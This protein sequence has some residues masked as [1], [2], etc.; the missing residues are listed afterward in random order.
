VTDNSGGTATKTLVVT[1]QNRAPTASFTATP[2]PSVTNATVTFNASAAV[3][4]DGTISKYEW[5]LDSN[6]SFETNGGTNK[7]TTRS[8]TT[9]GARTIGLRITDN[10]GATATTT[11][12]VTIQ[13]APPTPS[14]T[15]SP[16][17]ATANTT[18]TFNASASTDSNGTITKYE[19]DLDGNG[20]YETNGGTNKTTTRVYATASQV[21]VGLR[22]TDNEGATATTTQT[23][24]VRGPYNA[25]ISGTSDL[26]DYW[27]L[28]EA[29]GSTF[30]DPIGGRDATALNG[31]TL[32]SAGA[33]TL[34]TNTAA[35]FDGTNDAATASLNLS[36]TR[37]LT[38][39]FWLNWSTYAND[40]KLAFEFTPNFNNTNGGFLI[41]PNSSTSSGRF[42]VA[43]G[44]NG[45]RNNA[46]FTRPSAGAWHHYAIVL[47][48]SAL[49]SSQYI[50]VYVDG[51]AV[52]IT[53]GS[54]GNGAGSFANSTLYFMSRN[55]N[56]LFGKGA[57]D[58]VAIYDNT[59]S[60]TQIAQHY[61]AR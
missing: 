5:D 53:K 34:D 13:N 45:T 46:Y 60:A 8:Y 61:A 38:V 54:S 7:T 52:S 22:I 39:E 6:G 57:L 25:A 48:T 49:L 11:Q 27:R 41:N 9:V 59:L 42:E 20:S 33:L 28:G 15:V 43:I 14:F 35:S 16:S 2:N 55:G 30:D 58:E 23:L 17:P 50:T 26:I 44:R 1:L 24:T 12:S 51:K 31:V 3:D 21:V 10:S 29:S 40:D 37:Q 36:G 32:G 47:N 18:V 19:W 56:S 4:P